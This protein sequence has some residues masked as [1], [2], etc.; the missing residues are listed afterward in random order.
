M[1]MPAEAAGGAL[2]PAPALSPWWL[3]ARLFLAVIRAFRRRRG[4]ATGIDG[5]V[6]TTFQR[7]KASCAAAGVAV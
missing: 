6:A 1:E 7:W 5:G 3:K 4:A 2:V